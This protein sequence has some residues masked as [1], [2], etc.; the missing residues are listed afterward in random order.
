MPTR[1]SP[2]VSLCMPHLNSGG[3]VHE[4]MRSIVSQTLRD[5]E[6]IIVDSASTDGSL[7]VLEQYAA[8]D[9]R[10]RIHQAPRDGIYSNINRAIGMS[11]GRFVYLAT[12]D[13]T[14]ASDC[15]ESMVA[16]LE[17]HPE[18]GFAHCCLT[19][20]D[21]E[22]H[23]LVGPESWEN[24]ESQRH[25]GDWL[26]KSHVRRAP[27]D[28]LL[29][30]RHFTVFTSLTQ[31]LVR[32]ELYRRLGAF[33]TDRSSFA[34]FE[35]EMK[36]SLV[37][38]VVHVPRALATWRRHGRQATKGNMLVRARAAGEFVAMARAALSW[39]SLERS[40]IAHAVRDRRML[41]Y[42]LYDQL[43]ACQ[44]LAGSPAE[45]RRAVCSF[46][47]R[48]PEF[49]LALFRRRLLKIFGVHRS[50]SIDD[51][52]RALMPEGGLVEA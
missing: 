44:A 3:F 20:I 9:P 51:D 33:R 29:H 52:I 11:W 23:A 15:L 46:C 27:H 16:A 48:E 42:Y 41:R 40:V 25:F 45:R 21:E 14:M 31:L 7:E 37:E 2:Q 34:D 8:S 32:R 43:E 4:R 10:I 30:F 26:R 38:N 28:G 36:A 19:I 24:Y 47:V 12:S 5:W 49:A 6:L 18:C 50:A 1:P 39:L 35:W 17:A 13:D 22:G